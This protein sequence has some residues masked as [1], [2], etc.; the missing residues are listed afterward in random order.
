M[1]T[2]VSRNT[3]FKNYENVG[4][5]NTTGNGREQPCQH[6]K[7][8]AHENCTL[9]LFLV[10]LLHLKIAITSLHLLHIF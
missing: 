1:K 7:A 9:M 3:L 4:F 6:L 10:F 2:P 5:F 8:H